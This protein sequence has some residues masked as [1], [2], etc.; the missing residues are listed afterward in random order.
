MVRIE[1]NSIEG[2]LSCKAD[3]FGTRLEVE[4]NNMKGYEDISTSGNDLID[5]DIIDDD[6]N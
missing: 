3:P 4:L 2:T 5:V 6:D 1:C